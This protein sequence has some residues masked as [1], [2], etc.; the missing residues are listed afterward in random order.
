[1]AP[2]MSDRVRLS[3]I[4]GIRT[5]PVR[6]DEG[7]IFIRLSEAS[8]D[9]LLV[10]SSLLK[11]HTN[12]FQPRAPSNSTWLADTSTVTHP[13]TGKLVVVYNYYLSAFMEEGGT[14]WLLHNF[15]GSAH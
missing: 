11:K 5:Q 1:M 2:Y 3:V 12:W 4:D 10:K 15:V 13:S 9:H 7:D 14:A 6:Q 8:E